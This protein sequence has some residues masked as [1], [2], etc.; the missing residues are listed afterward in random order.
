M[1]NPSPVAPASGLS[2]HILPPN[3]FDPRING[4][5][6]YT[7]MV[8]AGNSPAPNGGGQNLAAGGISAPTLQIDAGTDFYLIAMSYQA[9]VSGAGGLEES[10]NIVPL[11]TVQLNDSG[12][13]RNLFSAAVPVGAIAGDGK[14]PYRLVRPRIFRANSSLSFTFTSLEPANAF[15]HLY[16]LLH[17]YR[18]FTAA[19]GA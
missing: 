7:Y 14:R 13:T 11:V 18:R 2:Q 5:D 19:A 1:S 15:A 16:L 10:T 17:G 9:Q 6:W 4:A 3:I 8:D 12:S